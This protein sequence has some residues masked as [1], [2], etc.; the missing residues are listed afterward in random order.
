MKPVVG[1]SS[2]RRTLDTFYGPDR[3]QTLSTY[4]TDSVSAAGM[5]P[6]VFVIAGLIFLGQRRKGETP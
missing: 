6:V 2:W 1:I 4:Y 3:L 5:T